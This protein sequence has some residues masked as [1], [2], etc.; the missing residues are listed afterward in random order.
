MRLADKSV[1]ITGAG[2]GVGRASALLFAAEGARV[3][4][5]DVRADWAAETVELVTKNGGTALA[6]H[7]DVTVESDVE[8]AVAAATRNFGRLDVMF[9]NAGVTGLKPGST[10]E[11]DTT[12]DFERLTTINVRGVFYGCKHAVRTFKAQGGGGVIVNTGS[13]AGMV[14]FG[15]VIYGATKAAINQLTRGVAIECAADDIRCN[16]ICPGTM[17]LTNF[18][19]VGDGP[20][21]EEYLRMAAGLQPNGRYVTAE[22]CAAAA[23]FLASDDARNVTGVLLPVDGGYVAR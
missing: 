1:V 6:H 23:L 8:A 21:P 22:D 16:A 10:F 12:E 14:G 9:N 19:R 4:C 17:P 18:I 20:P 2:S 7:C 13:I 15:S 3:V 5:A 11:L